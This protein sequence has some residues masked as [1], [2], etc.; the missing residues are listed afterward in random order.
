MF[1]INS[2]SKTNWKL[3][4]AMVIFGFL[5]SGILAWQWQEQKEE[6]KAPEKVSQNETANWQTY[7][8]EEYGFEVEYP[9]DWFVRKDTSPFGK[10]IHFGEKGEEVTG[11]FG[12]KSRIEKI[13]FTVIF[14]SDTSEL[15]GKENKLSLEDW[16]SKTFL[17]LE[18]GEI[19]E[20]IA[21]G[22]SNYPAI[23]LKKYK[24]VGV[25]EL[26]TFMFAE[27]DG[28]IYEIVGYVPALPTLDFPSEY[29][30]DKV[31]GQ[32]LSTFRFLTPRR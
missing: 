13:G 8:N 9:R 31:F 23:L 11:A 24:G 19:K 30:Y 29:N 27:K 6:I 25:I 10:R 4:G 1:L 22:V 16:I 7:R 26:I 20:N 5:A 3:L 32:M 28:A 15:Q 14:Y 17:P 18:E 12:G 21:F 2:V